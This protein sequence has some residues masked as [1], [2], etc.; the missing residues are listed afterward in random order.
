M[1]RTG[2]IFIFLVGFLTIKAQRVLTLDSCRSMALR[3]NKQLHISRLQRE[4]AVNT[5][6][7]VQ[8][9]YLP[10]VNGIG[11]YQ[12]S[13]KEVSILNASQKSALSNVGTHLT[14][15][16]GEV[17]TG[18]VSDL[19]QKGIISIQQAQFFEGILETA[20]TSVGSML[21]NAGERIKNAFRTDTRNMFVGSVNVTQPIYMGGA[22]TAA[23]KMAKIG[24]EMASDGV[25]LKL[26]TI[27]HETDQAY[28]LVVSLKQKRRLAE[29]YLQLIEQF[30]NDVKK[31]IDEGV[32]T[33]ADG[34]RTDVRVNEAEMTKIQVEDG[35]VLAKMY[36]CQLCGI[37]MDE[38]ITLFDED[39][40][41]L[42]PTTGMTLETAN[43]SVLL[44]PDNRPELRILQNTVDLTKWN[45]KLT[46]AAYLPQIAAIG[47]YTISNPSVFN[48]F[49]RKFKGLFHIGVAARIPIWS[50]FEGRYKIRANR[51]A[52]QIAQLE[53]EDAREK[54]ELQINQNRFKVKEAY[55]KLAMTRKNVEQAEENLRCEKLGFQEGVMQITEVMAA[56]TAW[57]QAHTQKIDAEI[58][59]KLSQVDLLKALGR[60][61]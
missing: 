60:L 41:E 36:L 2:I 25:E 9:K 46:R 45:T 8:T 31:M 61:Q 47:G 57:Q 39:K 51:A 38:D 33:R 43:D 5:R 3:N 22:I 20:G 12:F 19:V 13:D 27:R 49:E 18:I 55:K 54:I 48:G 34:L 4:V 37:P 14:S 16:T 32:A 26:Q 56:Q 17:I 30:N 11:T 35:L 28:W 6:K 42:E 44:N 10:K 53:Y 40:E 24:E 59:V 58:E 7:A 1:K 52:T 23:N 21:N 29:S 50:W 15:Q